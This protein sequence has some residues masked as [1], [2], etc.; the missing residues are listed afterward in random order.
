MV[1]LQVVREQLVGGGGLVAEVAAVHAGRGHGE[2]AEAVE[3]HLP[4]VEEVVAQL[5]AAP[6]PLG[7]DV[8]E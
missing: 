3:E 4:V 2:D 7:G 6:R 1:R 8:V 5:L